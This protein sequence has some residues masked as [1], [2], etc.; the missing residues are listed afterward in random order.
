MKQIITA[1]E[2]V[3]MLRPVYFFILNGQTA[4]LIH[5][6]DRHFLSKNIGNTIE[7]DL[8]HKR[9]DGGSSLQIWLQHSSHAEMLC[10]WRRWMP[11]CGTKQWGTLRNPK[12]GRRGPCRIDYFWFV[13]FLTQFLQF[14]EFLQFSIFE[15]RP[16]CG[17]CAFCRMDRCFECETANTRPQCKSKNAWC[18]WQVPATREKMDE[19]ERK[20]AS[21]GKVR[22]GVQELGVM[23]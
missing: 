15:L 7:N 4:W 1:I 23:G 17:A 21:S 9:G 6:D 11:M 19:S 20:Q 12:F 16:S 8:W 3:S 10:R 18:Y 5:D 13:I 22:Q 14:L 2:V